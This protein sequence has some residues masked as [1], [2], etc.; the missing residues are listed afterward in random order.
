M[1]ACCVPVVLPTLVKPEGSVGIVVL[2]LYAQTTIKSPAVVL[3]M[4]TL[5]ATAE[6]A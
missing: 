6:A 4:D 1:A 2:P 3:E 5:V